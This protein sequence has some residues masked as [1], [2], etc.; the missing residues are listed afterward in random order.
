MC[1]S[2]PPSR[3]GCA[4]ALA[5]HRAKRP[6]TSSRN[7]WGQPAA[8]A[9]RHS[10]YPSKE[11]RRSYR[12]VSGPLVRPARSAILSIAFRQPCSAS[13]IAFSVAALASSTPEFEALLG[14]VVGGVGKSEFGC[15]PVKAAL[16]SWCR[17]CGG[18][19]FRASEYDGSRRSKPSV[20]G[21]LRWV[22]YAFRFRAWPSCV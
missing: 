9:F 7:R 18:G 4:G 17:G 1:W 11:W 12:R 20:Y 13:F 5:P 8:L 6:G 2:R 19:E 10:Q 21:R 22:A 16:P 14:S 15:S 3:C